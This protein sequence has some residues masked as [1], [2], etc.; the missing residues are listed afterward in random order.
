[1]NSGEYIKEIISF[2][3]ITPPT[4]R[5][6]PSANMYFI[7]FC[8]VSLVRSEEVRYNLDIAGISAVIRTV[9]IVI[10]ATMTLN[11]KLYRAVS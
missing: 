7:T 10:N 8:C 9:G 2:A 5:G 3:K 6:I 11:D 4:E 1:M